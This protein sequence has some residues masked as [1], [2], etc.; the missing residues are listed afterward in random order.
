MEEL[1]RAA[2]SAAGH[3]YQAYDKIW[4]RV[5][6]ELDPYPEIRSGAA[7]QRQGELLDLP[8]AQRDPCCMGTQARADID[9]IVG[10]VG[11]EQRNVQVFNRFAR[12]TQ[13]RKTA[14]A[15]RKIAES[16]AEHLRQLLAVYYL[17][18]GECYPHKQYVI[19]APAGSFCV[20]LRQAYHEKACGGFNYLRAADAT[21]DPCLQTL[22]RTFGEEELAHAQL[23]L[24]LLSRRM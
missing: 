5:A 11:E 19:T 10:F 24:K 23:L 14:A 15:L 4:Q 8:G 21:G 9:V 13:E 6:P 17:V 12:S 3:D 22:F 2:Q 20:A 16:A 7:Q 18:M 1:Y